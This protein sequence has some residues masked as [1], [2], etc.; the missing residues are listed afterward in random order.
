MVEVGLVQINNSFSGQ[1]YLPYSVACLQSYARKNLAEPE[2][3]SFLPM[4]YKRMPIHEIV[5]RLLPAQIV[6][7][8]IYVWNAQI[9]LEAA[10]RLKTQP[11]RYAHRVR[12]VRMCQNEPEAVS[13][14]ARLH[15]H[16]RP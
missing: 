2:R 9:S 12:A 1:N 11:T 15:R 8:S 5:E 4:V 3:F 7:F 13:P 16:G 10:R 6:G 14:S